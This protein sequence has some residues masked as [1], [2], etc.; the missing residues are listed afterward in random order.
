[1]DLPL[2][3]RGKPYNDSNHTQ[4]TLQV[5]AVAVAEVVGL[6]IIFIFVFLYFLL[7][8]FFLMNKTNISHGRHALE[9]IS[10]SRFYGEYGWLSLLSV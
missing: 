10:K 4:K 1:M 6:G 9:D 8:K 7:S 2:L 3:T 5:L